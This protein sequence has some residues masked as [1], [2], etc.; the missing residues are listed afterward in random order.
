V[1]GSS[2]HSAFS[3]RNSLE[4]ASTTPSTST[5]PGGKR[6]SGNAGND[7]CSSTQRSIDAG[8]G[9]TRKK[10]PMGEGE[11]SSTG[12]NGG[13]SNSAVDGGGESGLEHE[14]DHEI[15]SF[16]RRQQNGGDGGA[17][18]RNLVQFASSLRLVPAVHGGGEPSLPAAARPGG[19]T[20]TRRRGGGGKGHRRREEQLLDNGL[21]KLITR[22]HSLWSVSL[23]V[24]SLGASRLCLLATVD[25]RA[26]CDNTI[27]DQVREVVRVLP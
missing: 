21:V 26:S 15:A 3:H 11:T 19:N 1:L 22:H 25:C 9:K 16:E 24:Q 18:Q 20:R 8:D 5:Y 27:S 7:G 10:H 4:G 13:T 14:H 6:H 23:A 17:V 12:T 2:H